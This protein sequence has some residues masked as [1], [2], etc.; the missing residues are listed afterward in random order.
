MLLTLTWTY[1]TDYVAGDNSPVDIIPCTFVKGSDG[2]LDF[3]TVNG[4]T[5]SVVVFG[6]PTFF[7]SVKATVGTFSFVAVVSGAA[8]PWGVSMGAGV[9]GCAVEFICLLAS[10]AK[11]SFCHLLIFIL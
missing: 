8:A 2:A 11:P 4:A 7:S 6:L 9:E 3:L 1:A 5:S 10:A